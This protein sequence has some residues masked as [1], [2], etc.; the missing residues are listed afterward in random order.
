MPASIF[1]SSFYDPDDTWV[2][3]RITGLLKSCGVLPVQLAC[4]QAESERIIPMIRQH[5]LYC[6]VLTSRSSERMLA[7]VSLEIGAALSNQ[8]KVIVFREKEIPMQEEYPE[9][10][11]LEYDRGPIQ[12]PDAN[13]SDLSAQIREL[14][15]LYGLNSS[16]TPI[17]GDILRRYD[18]AREQAQ[19]LGSTILRYYNDVLYPNRI[20]NKAVKNYPTNAD[21]TANRIISSEISNHQEFRD[22]AIISEEDTKDPTVLGRLLDESVSQTE[23][24]WVIDPLDGTLN[25]AYN[26]PYFCVSIGVLRYNEP[27]IGIVFN[28]T[29]QELYCGLKGTRS[30]CID[31]RSGQK[32]MLNTEY[33]KGALEDCIVM[34]HL[35]TREH[36]RLKTIAVLNAIMGRCRN[37]RML[38]SGQMSLVSIALGQFDIFFNYATNIWDVI[39]GSVILSGAGGYVTTS[40]V[41]DGV[42]DLRSAGILAAGNAAVG[43]Q[44]RELLF[45]ELEDDFPRL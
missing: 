12:N 40:L 43:R 41:A 13:L 21:I 38:G 45:S 22:D 32:K 31:L 14:L 24:T 30:E 15:T 26:F 6:A 3:D 44:I 18:F 34:T 2:V 33:H 19:L 27:V 9:K 16:G 37:I 1:I 4:P 8:R 39:P 10:V 28:P 25:F 17:D 11:Q 36:P 20:R 42:W 7:A 23:Y 5:E 35:S 29:T